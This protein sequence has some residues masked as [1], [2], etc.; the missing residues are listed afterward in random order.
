MPAERITVG[1]A[2]PMK[3]IIVYGMVAVSSLLLMGYSVHMLV[4][5]LVSERAEHI[6][7][8]V[9]VF[10]GVLGIGFMV[11]DVIRRRRRAQR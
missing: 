5:G 8:A 3:E 7:M 1:G 10:A 4:G 9:V 2:A 11:W 6:A